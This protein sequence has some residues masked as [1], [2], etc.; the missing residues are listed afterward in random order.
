MK[1][2]PLLLSALWM[3]PALL[4]GF[5]S[6]KEALDAGNKALLKSN[7]SDAE[8]CFAE[9][10]KL[11]KNPW[12]KTCAILKSAEVLEKEKKIGECEQKL[13]SILLL[14]NASPRIRTIGF[15]S[16]G[17]LFQKRGAYE[18]AIEYYR[19][20]IA[21]KAGDWSEIQTKLV[22]ANLLLERNTAEAVALY[23]SVIS[24]PKGTGV[25]EKVQAYFGLGRCHQ[26][27]GDVKE[28]LKSYELILNLPQA[29]AWF[30]QEAEK[31]IRSLKGQK[32]QVN[33]IRN[34][35]FEE[36]D[37]TGAIAEF[38][39]GII[40]SEDSVHG[41]YSARF[42]GSGA[43]GTYVFQRGIELRP[44]TCYRF[45]ASLKCDTDS[46]V[47]K[48][49]A[50]GPYSEG[51]M[52]IVFPENN[53][54]RKRA[55]TA[56]LRGGRQ[57]WTRQTRYFK[58]DSRNLKF[59]I[60]LYVLGTSGSAWFDHLELVECSPE[61]YRQ[62]KNLF[63]YT[64]SPG[65]NLIYN[66]SFEITT[67]PDL[68]DGIYNGIGEPWWKKD[69]RPWGNQLKIE[70]KNS[71]HGI[72]H[73]FLSNHT[74]L[75]YPEFSSGT[76]KVSLSF[77]AKS[78]QES[79]T[80][81]VFWG[82]FQQTFPLTNQWKTFTA[83]FDSPGK[84]SVMG[85]SDQG[86][87]GVALDAVMLTPGE[88]A[89]PYA[90]SDREVCN[91]FSWNVQREPFFPSG[92]PML[93]SD[94]SPIRIPGRIPATLTISRR[95]ECL[96]VRI[97]C[98]GVSAVSPGD[99]I[100][101]RFLGVPEKEN[102][103]YS[104]F[105][106]FA[107]GKTES[108]FPFSVKN[109]RNAGE[110]DAALEIPLQSAA[111]DRK[112]AEVWGFNLMRISRGTS[113]REKEIVYLNGTDIN[114]LARLR[115]GPN[116]TENRIPELRKPEKLL[117]PA[118]RKENGRVL[119]NG[120]KHMLAVDG[121]P[122]I[123]FVLSY[124]LYPRFPGTIDEVKAI[125]FDTVYLW[126]IGKRPSEQHA[127]T[128][129]KQRNDIEAIGKKGLFV[130]PQL[131]YGKSSRNIWSSR[132]FPLEEILGTHAEAQNALR[133]LPCILAWASL[134]EIYGSWEKGKFPKKEEDIR[135]VCGLL[136]NGDGRPVF[137]NVFHGGHVYGGV[138]NFDIV[139]ASLYT[140][141]DTKGVSAFCNGAKS[142]MDHIRGKRSPAV[143]GAWIQY[144]NGSGEGG[145]REPTVRELSA[146]IYG[147]LIHG[148]RMFQFF[149]DRPN[150]N[151][152][153]FGTAGIISE[154][155]RLT[156]VLYYGEKLPVAT[157]H[158]QVICSAYRFRDA[159]YLIAQNLSYSP[160]KEITITAGKEKGSHPASVL[161]ENRS[162]ISRSGSITDSFGSLERH[163]YRI[164]L[165][166][167][168]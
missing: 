29:P 146:M 118:S 3:L 159:V 21:Q 93:E 105:K 2:T 85:F 13:Q 131:L 97:R 39:P 142:I 83:T 154:V 70:K 128:F 30:R 12:E 168:E 19:K 99:S 8:A 117:S 27:T 90:K 31:R 126:N 144:Y 45:S 116:R 51:V 112:A 53:D 163:V 48:A 130:I 52:A 86:G 148:L 120:E 124:T 35:S 111:G 161:F 65:E 60:G 59:W 68:P 36:V 84:R 17:F 92:V 58:T 75:I 49:T 103:N 100:T 167:A 80:L 132:E 158:T 123:P 61:E 101:L 7:Y 125:G 72:R 23:R 73:L 9:A 47:P 127:Y 71:P 6:S 20:G 157:N 57:N 22:L 108:K 38:S 69:P 143:G 10:E 89:F 87:T 34:P 140:I 28:A 114:D 104:D 138:E 149:Q 113:E 56:I 24:D 165:R 141:R 160:L 50:Y 78:H 91:E 162:V 129:D 139:S 79:G 1:L 96:A 40:R 26:K 121:K 64:P 107:D 41:N 88:K 55:A 152:L 137:G 25:S 150:S 122:W 95:D 110:W 54:W 82:G 42:D 32:N 18:K 11:A 151:V 4:S 153:W 164:P 5:N 66:G 67:N 77:H 147:G 109:I 43:H 37:K 145:S 98:T 115:I 106:V 16:L 166:N 33:L 62:G 135:K 14:E 155:R 76:R 81:R 156:D 133:D 102:T 15:K 63:S 74:Y 119:L 136:R 94:G 46:L 134:D 44:N